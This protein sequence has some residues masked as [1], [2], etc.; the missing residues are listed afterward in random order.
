MKVTLTTTTVAA[1][2]L[3]LLSA[4][5]V[6]AQWAV[7][8]ATN[9]KANSQ[10]AWNTSL[11][12]LKQ[13]DQWLK[14]VQQYTLQA[15]Q[16]QAQVQNLLNLPNQVYADVMAPANQVVGMV[17]TAP[18]G[19]PPLPNFQNNFQS[20]SSWNS[21]PVT[22][23]GYRQSMGTASLNEIAA[24][25]AAADSLI[26][27]GAS[28]IQGAQRLQQMVNGS[29]AASGNLQAIKAQNQ[30]ASAQ[31]AQLQEMRGLLIHQLEV[32]AARNASLANR[33]AAEAVATQQSLKAHAG[34]Y[35]AVP[36]NMAMK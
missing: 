22:V 15:Q 14:Q 29:Q 27:Q 23:S 24:Y 2:S 35:S 32:T 33:E 16:Y 28:M 12:Y 4:G 3:A 21:R 30:L 10:S 36:L 1:F 17:S 31:I 18:V 5:T 19:L 6:H 8:D 25:V 26:N 7:I 20:Y 13:G 34:D 11:G 9:L